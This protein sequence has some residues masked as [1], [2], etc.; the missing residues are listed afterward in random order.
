[1]VVYLAK[2]RDSS[3]ARYDYIL[4]NA[5]LIIHWTKLRLFVKY[6]FFEQDIQITVVFMSTSPSLC[7]N[8][9]LQIQGQRF[10]IEILTVYFYNYD[11][12]VLL[13]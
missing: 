1:M 5:S 3:G 8:P 6:P 7:P 2:T 11:A 10:F 12:A 13:I 4:Q 9:Y